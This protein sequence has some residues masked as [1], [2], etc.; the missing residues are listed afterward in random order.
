MTVF[1]PDRTKIGAK[2]QNTGHFAYFFIQ[3]SFI[4]VVDSTKRFAPTHGLL[5]LV[6]MAVFGPDW[7]K[8]GTRTQT[9][10]TFKDL[11]YS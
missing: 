8:I 11:F 2:N 9:T 1:G 7:T 5:V 3:N 10:G 6:K 4:Y